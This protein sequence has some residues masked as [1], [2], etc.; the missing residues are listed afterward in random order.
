MSFTRP[1]V[2][3]SLK[4][5]LASTN[6]CESTTAALGALWVCAPLKEGVILTPEGGQGRLA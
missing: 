6:L 2:T 5:R 1:G 3:G 4:R